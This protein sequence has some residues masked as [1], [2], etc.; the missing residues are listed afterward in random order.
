M[1]PSIGFSEML[2]LAVLAII[3]V[4]P[5]QM[6][7]MMRTLGQWVGK[8]KAMGQEFKDAFEDMG[9]EGEMA[10]LRKEIEELKKMGKLEDFGDEDLAHEMSAL[11]NDIRAS[12]SLDN[13]P[14]MSPKDTGPNVASD[15]RGS[16][17]K[18]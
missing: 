5:A 15:K 9:R 11:D 4:G 8:I 13:H 17:G 14:R 2:L 7:T 18:A 6:P 12:T 16:D 1:I 3:F 10:E